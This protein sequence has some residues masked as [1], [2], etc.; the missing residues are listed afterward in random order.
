MTYYDE[1]AQSFIDSTL[2]LDMGELYKK[3]EAHLSPGASILDLGCGPGRDLKY[4]SATYKGSGLEP[5]HKLYEHA[6]NY[7]Q[8]QVFET[9]IQ[10]FKPTEKYDGIW[11]CASLLHVPTSELPSV[12][13][14]L[15]S[16]LNDNG[17]I[18]VSFKLGNFEGDRNGRYFS[19]LTE[20]S[21]TSLLTSTQL[22]I[23]ESWITSDI[24]PGRE[25]E[26]WLNVIIQ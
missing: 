5:C 19:D 12:F 23:T 14:K 9:T 6:K 26:K 10:D 8:C 1:N 7:T 21:L 4:F 22:K 2:D 3:F 17:V 13:L 15:E 11:A 24:R 18:Y 20:D 16:M 25:S